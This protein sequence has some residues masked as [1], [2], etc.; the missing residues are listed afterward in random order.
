MRFRFAAGSS[1]WKKQDRACCPKYDCSGWSAPPHCLG[2]HICRFHGKRLGPR[3]HWANGTDI[4]CKFS[5]RQKRIR[6]HNGFRRR[7]IRP[8]K[9]LVC[10]SRRKVPRAASAPWTVWRTHRQSYL[11]WS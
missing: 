9:R 8:Q 2:I 11:A 4:H 7:Y 1:H 6:K 5:L 10:R 3:A